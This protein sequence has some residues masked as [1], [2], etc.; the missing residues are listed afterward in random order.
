[1]DSHSQDKEKTDKNAKLSSVK[2]NIGDLPTDPGLRIPIM[3]YHLNVCD[4]VRRAYVLRGVLVSPKII[5]FP[6]R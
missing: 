3:A 5:F 1:M 2:F 6:F 4:E